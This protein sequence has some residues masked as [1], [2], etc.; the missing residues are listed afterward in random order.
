MT[1]A[2]ER[3]VDLEAVDI[4]DPRLYAEGDPDAVFRHL[5]RHRP[6]GRM[7]RPDGPPFWALV[8]HAHQDHV[9]RNPS[10]FS[11]TNGVTLDTI[12]A[13]GPD[14]AAGKMLEFSL[15][16]H[17][18][19]LRT[20][21]S[22]LYNRRA[23][24]E[25]EPTIRALAGRLLDEALAM[26]S[27]NFAADVA[28]PMTSAVVFG[29]LG[30]PEADWWELFDLSRRSQEETHVPM[31]A[32]C[33]FATSA[34]EANHQ[35][36]KYMMRL[37]A[38]QDGPGGHIGALGH[39]APGG[40][41]LTKQEVILNTLNIMQGG[42]STTRHAATGGL[43]ALLD[44]P[45]QLERVENDQRLVPKL[46]EEIVRWT[47]PAVHLARTATRTVQVGGETIEKGDI[48]TVWTISSNRDEDAFRDPYRFDAGRSPNKH[49]G[50]LSGPHLCLGIHVARIELRIL[51]EELLKRRPSLV[52]AGEVRRVASNFIAGI[53]SLPLEVR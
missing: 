9:H 2:P 39:A 33:P 27:F 50:F 29:L 5:R 46:V 12:R 11:T 1:I 3:G 47:S 43:M 44:H 10:I 26:G 42:N 48:V 51:F 28:D 35:L 24:A 20:D 14:P 49:L 52:R 34:N 17:H 45:D 19:V 13:A 53:E 32:G 22:T 40:T 6:V 36:L 38:D 21:F 4:S 18:K 37:L 16:A 7:E 25:L 8:K 41:P 23:I 30:F 15:P 31:G